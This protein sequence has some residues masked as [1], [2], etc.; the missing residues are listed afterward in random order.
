MRVQQQVVRDFGAYNDVFLGDFYE[1]QILYLYDAMIDWMGPGGDE[2]F[3]TMYLLSN[4]NEP[5]FEV[6]CDDDELSLGR[7]MPSPTDLS[8]MVNNLRQKDK[9]S[10][11]EAR[12]NRSYYP[13]TAVRLPRVETI[14]QDH[15]QF[16][17]NI[18]SITVYPTDSYR[19]ALMG[20]LATPW[21]V[22]DGPMLFHR[23][24]RHV[25]PADR[26]Y[27]ASGYIP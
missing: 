16:S 27:D 25:A 1:K 4:I 12:A 18:A 9:S 26:P 8:T 14:F 2:A 22:F 13:W 11:R 19:L 15:G 6:I 3:L 7:R 24:Q 23:P 10:R 20:E 17:W 5:L 21:E